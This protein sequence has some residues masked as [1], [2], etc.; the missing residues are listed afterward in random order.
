MLKSKFK[1]IFSAALSLIITCSLCCYN[2]VRSV[3]TCSNVL[4]QARDGNPSFGNS[5]IYDIGLLGSHDA[6]S[7]KINEDS[8]YTSTTSVPQMCGLEDTALVKTIS[9]NYAR[10][11]SKS[12]DE[13]LLRGVR[14]V[15]ARIAQLDGVYRTVHSLFGG[16]LED[17]LKE[18]LEFLINNPGEFVVFDIASFG[19]D[20]TDLANFMGSIKVNKNGK[21]YNIYDFIHYD[22]SKNFADITYN[23][24]TK[25]GDCAGLVIVANSIHK[26]PDKEIP[27]SNASLRDY[28][29]YKNKYTY[30][31]NDPSSSSLISK[32]DDIVKSFDREDCVGFKC[33]QVN[34]TPCASS[35]ALELATGSLIKSAQKHNITVL[36]DPRFEYWLSVMPCVWFDDV[37]TDYGDFN[38]KVNQK[39][40]DYNLKLNAR[41]EPKIICEKLTSSSQLSNKTKI[42]IKSPSSCDAFFGDSLNCRNAG[43]YESGKFVISDDVKDFW[44][45]V[46]SADGWKIML[47]NGSYLKRVSGNLKTTPTNGSATSFRFD[48]SDNGIAKIYEPATIKRN[49]YLDGSKLD[50]SV[51]KSAK[52]EVYKVQ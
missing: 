44:T 13:Q 38:N 9:V 39:I 1:K 32:I 40:L 30:W 5:K 47:S 14:Y 35:I 22:T 10:A 46:K 42:L 18:L 3:T 17:Y 20:A 21:D 49:L 4:R 29:K 8:P 37:T 43:N 45:L 24:V 16:K 27:I 19:G 34:T 36:D 33:N 2:Q 28:F 6:L 7:D 25:N 11:Q 50:L 12:L 23:D 51:I 31:Y 52:F 48:I 15:D 41:K 26:A